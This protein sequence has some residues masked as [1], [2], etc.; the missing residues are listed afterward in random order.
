M[1]LNSVLCAFLYAFVMILPINLA[2]TGTKKKTLPSTTITAPT[3]TQK[4]GFGQKIS[5]YF[6]K[7]QKPPVFQ[8]PEQISTETAQ[9]YKQIAEGLGEMSNN[10]DLFNYKQKN[11]KEIISKEIIPYYYQ[12]ML[13]VINNFMTKDLPAL[14]KSP[15]FARAVEKTQQL[16]QQVLTSIDTL[17]LKSFGVK[18]GKNVGD[19]LIKNMKEQAQKAITKVVNQDLDEALKAIVSSLEDIY[20]GELPKLIAFVN[21]SIKKD[22]SSGWITTEKRGF[23]AK[24]ITNN[25]DASVYHAAEAINDII[26]MNEIILI[27]IKRNQFCL[28]VIKNYLEKVSS[29]SE[30]ITIR[31]VAS[32]LASLAEDLAEHGIKNRDFDLLMLEVANELNPLET[33]KSSIKELIKKLTPPKK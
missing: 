12:H 32:A 28:T 29:S 14:K 30:N 4:F 15:N 20:Q 19:Q 24:K 10:F 11:Q 25:V 1:K 21:E 17:N 5:K 13:H 7:S 22:T 31:G 2:S 6:K 27:G 9:A 3:T 8:N 33:T 26:N 16:L 23:K 18:D